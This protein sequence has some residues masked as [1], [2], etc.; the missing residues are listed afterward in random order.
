MKEADRAVIIGYSLPA[1]DVELALLFKRGLRALAPASHHS[2]GVRPRATSTSLRTTRTPLQRHPTGQRF[3]SLFGSGLDW[4]TAG[5]E[6]WLI[7]QKHSRR[8]PFTES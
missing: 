5:F 8:F 3:R 2:G 4:H 7:E 6:S 1:D